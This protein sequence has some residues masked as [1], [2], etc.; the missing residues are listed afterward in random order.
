[1]KAS[2]FKKFVV[3]EDFHYLDEEV[4]RSLAIDLKVFHELSELVFVVVGVWLEA[5]KLTLYNGDL[6]GRVAV[7]DADDWTTTELR[8][9]IGLGVGLLNVVMDDDVRDAIVEGCQNNVGLLQEVCYRLCESGEV[10]VTCPGAPK[11]IGT[12]DEVQ[13]MLRAVADEQSARYRNFLGR[14]AEGLGSTQLEMYKW[15]AFAVVT[16][17]SVELRR[18]IRPNI[19]FSKIRDRHP[20]AETLQQNN[21]LQALD[22]VGTVQFKHKL[23]PLILD[24]SNGELVV[25]DANFLIFMKTQL[26]RRAS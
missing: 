14:F 22:R 6:T 16:S 15:I 24:Y 25:V 21:I 18:G 26:D 1:M 11:P 7:I 9:V 13:A 23:Q 20:S 2:G 3:V 8:K 4:Q 12:V 10:F 19:L 5:N 17:D